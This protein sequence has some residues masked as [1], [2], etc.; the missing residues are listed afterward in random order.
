MLVICIKIHKFSI[1]HIVWNDVRL[2]SCF[3][4]VCVIIFCVFEEAGGVQVLLLEACDREIVEKRSCVGQ[5][6]LVGAVS[7]C[8]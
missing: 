4:L 7:G 5:G 2:S 1:K 3:L 6:R 8:C